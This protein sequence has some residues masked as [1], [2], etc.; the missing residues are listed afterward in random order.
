VALA[1]AAV[2]AQARLP[3]G[4]GQV[5]LAGG[6]DLQLDGAEP[7]EQVGLS[8]AGAGDVNGDGVGDLV[9]GAPEADH[10]ANMD[11]GSAYVLFGVASGG[12]FDALTFTNG[13]RIDGELAG[14]KAGRSVAG[15]G[16]MNGDGLDDVLIGE[17]DPNN[18]A[19][20]RATVVFGKTSD[21]TVSLG[22]LG[23]GGFR[24]VG[25]GPA[26]RA[27]LSVAGGGDVNGDG[28]DDMLVAAPF[29][30]FNGRNDAGSVYVVF[31]GS[32]ADV[33]LGALGGR[34]FRI[35]GTADN[36]FLGTQ[37]VALG[38]VNGDGLADVVA[39]E[40]FDDPNGR[41]FAGSTYVVF[42]SAST[43]NVDLLSLGSRGFRI[44]G[45]APDDDSGASVGTVG[46]MT[47][48]GRA[49]V[50]VGA[51]EADPAGRANAGSAYL[52]YG[53]TATSTVDLAGLGTAGVELQGPAP[54][55]E[56]GESS[57][58]LGDINRDGRGDF[59]IA[60]SEIDPLGRT[61]AGSAFAVL[62]GGLPNVVDLASLGT[63]GY[64]IDGGA[65]GDSMGLQFG[66]AGAGDIDR[67]G[68]SDVGVA[69]PLSNANGRGDSG[70]AYVLFGPNPARG[71]CA[72]PF[73][74]TSLADVIEGTALGDRVRAGG[75]NDRV[76][77]RGSGDCLLGE[78]GN[79]RLGG[80][81]AGDRLNGG[82]GK[83]RLSG[84]AGS[85]RLAGGP[86]NDRL[87]GGGGRD[88]L[89]AGAGNDQLNGGPGPDHL[90]GGAGRDVL[91]GKRG[92]KDR[93]VC[94]AGKRDLA[95]VD[96]ADRATASCERVKGP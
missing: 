18:V 94:G 41:A 31:G 96:A 1:V 23:G 2:A 74:G 33:D 77:G 63:R 91:R 24:I 30:V 43:A 25:D 88:R 34:G 60:G 86:G 14:D 52:V 44:D 17:G 20:G 84:A 40:P 71:A 26:D 49:E 3:Q 61:D 93:L 16:D 4:S 36:M 76:R 32:T 8:L 7:A 85:D 57:A 28:R 11:S 38:D 92:G 62:G 21:T 6:G 22:A 79:D 90:T 29:T 75:G 50:L 45:A 37:G 87:N 5:D 35:D 65:D 95:V 51:T 13:F 56:F 82:A 47:G 42:G 68:R 73:F 59:V 58:G 81:Q 89:N 48:D 19:E 54:D 78:G 55:G 15:V 69:A 10:N 67:D 12:T 66:V 27:G 70:S 9:V 64:R 80:D 53:R 39:S 72:N 83:D 46:D